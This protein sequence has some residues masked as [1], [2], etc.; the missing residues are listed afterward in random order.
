MV[1]A[2]FK[3]KMY[4]FSIMYT[5]L[6]L[7]LILNKDEKIFKHFTPSPYCLSYFEDKLYKSNEEFI[8]YNPG[9]E[10]TKTSLLTLTYSSEGSKV[11]HQVQSMS[12][13]A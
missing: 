8:S 1:V 3:Y 13:L 10:L 4:Q 2:I 12:F 7:M 11:I 5:I 6:K 9:H